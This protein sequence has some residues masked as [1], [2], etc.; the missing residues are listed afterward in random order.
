MDHNILLSFIVFKFKLQQRFKSNSLSFLIKLYYKE[1]LKVNPWALR[2]DARSVVSSA[3]VFFTKFHKVKD[4]V[5]R[6]L[7]T[8]DSICFL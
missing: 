3:K 5:R 7:W 6:I 4:L 2:T 8:H 1:T